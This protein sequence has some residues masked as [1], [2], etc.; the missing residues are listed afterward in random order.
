MPLRIITERVAQARIEREAARW[1]ARLHADDCDERERARFREWLRAD[2]THATAFEE[3]TTVWELVGA[4]VPIDA[5][6]P[7]QVTRRRL[8]LGGG[9]TLTAVAGGFFALSA[10]A[11]IYRTDVGER[12]SLVLADRSKVLLDADSELRVRNRDTGCEA[13]LERGRA[14]FDLQSRTTGSLLVRAGG[15]HLRIER[16]TF[17]IETGEG[18]AARILMLRGAGD[19]RQ[20][21]N[22]IRTL[23]TGHLFDE[24]S[25]SVAPMPAAEVERLTAW[26][27]G[28]A[29]FDNDSLAAAVQIMNRYDRQRLTIED[30]STEGLRISGTFRVGDNAAF[31]EALRA[32]LPL[33]IEASDEAL[34]LTRRAG[35]TAS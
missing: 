16:G 2:P 15:C 17:E 24:T 30:A 21:E 19:V 11:E 23:A 13:T 33:D 14:H 6:R 7:M 20:N 32:M 8:L 34:R 31:A 18:S 3:L 28:R 1:L 27:D 9:A 4:R 10:G 26:Q 22:P 25:T 29:I 5:H 35:R 12:R